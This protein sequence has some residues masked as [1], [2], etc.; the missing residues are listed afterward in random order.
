[1][2]RD[3]VCRSRRV[4]TTD[5]TALAMRDGNA[6]DRMPDEDE[7]SAERLV[8]DIV[9]AMKNEREVG[10]GARPGASWEAVLEPN[11]RAATNPRKI[12]I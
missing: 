6:A 2:G 12:K 4:C 9:Y 8:F 7:A 3:V 5:A 11:T 1:M 10:Q